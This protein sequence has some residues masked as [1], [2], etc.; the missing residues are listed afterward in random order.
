M[1]GSEL[2]PA[3]RQYRVE[4]VAY[5]GKVFVNRLHYGL[6]GIRS[7]HCNQGGKTLVEFFS[8]TAK[9]ACYEHPPVFI[10]RFT[11]GFQRLVHGA[12]NKTTGVDHDEVSILVTVTDR[13]ILGPELAQNTF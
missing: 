1:A 9:T 2:Y 13:I 4:G 5:W 11:D 7:R 3:R 6:T 12:L 8:P 10:Q